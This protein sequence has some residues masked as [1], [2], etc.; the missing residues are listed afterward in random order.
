MSETSFTPNLHIKQYDQSEIANDTSGLDWTLAI[1]GDNSDSMASIVDE[2][3]GKVNKSI[4]ELNTNTIKNISVNGK[5]Q[6][7]TNGTVDIQ[8]ST[9]DTNHKHTCL[10]DGINTVTM[11]NKTGTIALTSDITSGNSSDRLTDGTHTQTM[12]NKDGVIATLDDIVSGSDGIYIKD[13]H[14]V[15]TDKEQSFTITYLT[16]TIRDLVL[17]TDSNLLLVEGQD[18]TVDKTIKTIN[19]LKD[20]YTGDKIYYI[21]RG[22]SIDGTLALTIDNYYTKGEE[23]VT[24]ADLRQLIQQVKSNLENYNSLPIFSWG[25]NGGGVESD[26]EGGEIQFVKPDNSILTSN[27]SIDSFYNYIRFFAKT[28]IGNKIAI[29]DF[30]HLRTDH[31]NLLCTTEEIE[32]ITD[33]EML[34][35]FQLY[36][37]RSFGKVCR[38]GKIVHIN[39]LLKNNGASDNAIMVL[40]YPPCSNEIH[41]CD[42]FEFRTL[43][44]GRLELVGTLPSDGNYIVV[45]LNYACNLI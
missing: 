18:Y 21:I 39:F 23:D 34:N 33:I 40:P 19:L 14:V 28:E 45:D 7:K 36:D 1:N 11:P 10:S 8:I 44:N 5:T 24:H 6:S 20:F 2:F 35:G 25:K 43:T 13:V 26:K 22:N 3:A 41:K 42:S 31:Y 29:I 16:D 9:L 4:E 38:S 30:E 27:V 15:A 32:N 12:Q 37:D 17:F